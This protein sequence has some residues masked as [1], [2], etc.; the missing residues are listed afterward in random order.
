[1][2]H[3][4]TFHPQTNNLNAFVKGKAI[5]FLKQSFLIP[6]IF[7]TILYILMRVFFIGAE[8]DTTES[9]ELYVKTFLVTWT[10]INAFRLICHLI[11]WIE[12]RTSKAKLATIIT[13]DMLKKTAIVVVT[14]GLALTSKAKPMF[15]EKKDCINKVADTES[16]TDIDLKFY[17]WM[18]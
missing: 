3:I 14:A 11:I 16:L 12:S 7:S 9:V 2:Q 8:F 1:M 13:M 18:K 17:F 15:R 4:T 5:P 10:Y 6:F